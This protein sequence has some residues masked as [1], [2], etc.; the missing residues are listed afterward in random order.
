MMRI[1][2]ACLCLCWAGRVWA[3]PVA[4]DQETRAGLIAGQQQ[5]KAKDLKPYQ[6]NKAERWVKEA[7]QIVFGGQLHWHPFFESAYRGGGFT[8][9]AGYLTHVSDYN[10]LDVRASFTPSG[11]IRAESEFRAPRLF[12]GRGT[13]SVIGGWRKATQ[14]GYYGLGTDNTSQDDEALYSFEQPYASATLD[15]R[16]TRR[17]LILSGGADYSKWSPGSA[18]GNSPSIEEVYTPDTAPGLGA[19]PKYLHL[20]GGVAADSRTS[21][22][23]SRRGG[24]YAVSLH[25]YDDDQDLYSFRRVDYDAIQHVPLGRDAWVLSLRGR[26]ETT[27]TS[28]GNIVPYFMMPS[29]GGGSDMR[30]FNSWRFRDLNSLLLQAEWRVLVNAFFD[31]AL[32]YDAGKVTSRRADINLSDL[33]SDYGIG[34]RFHGPAA[35]PLRVDLAK[36]NE[37]FHLVFSANAVF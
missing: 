37:G 26:V 8:L 34:I 24:Y 33:K 18:D 32:F 3:Q 10:W 12:G 6:P 31:T 23:Y 29:L 1:A 9:G 15:V 20:F 27:Y 22:G 14:V 21:P 13:L 35:T 7:E 28:D 19:T 17:W 25:G 5:E 4:S 30:G 2:L 36:S 11:Y 16:P